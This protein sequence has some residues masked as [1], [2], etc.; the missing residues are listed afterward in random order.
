MEIFILLAL[1]FV[2]ALF[3]ISEIALVSARKSRLEHQAERGDQR[4]RTALELSNN[5][6]KFLSAAQ[7]G[8]T[9]IAILTG[10]YSGERFARYIQPSIEKISFLK[11]YAAT[12]STTIIVILVTFLSI[13]FGELIPKRIGL[14]RAERIAKLVAGPMN[15]FARFTHPFVWLLNK[16]SN[17]FFRIFNIRRSKDDAVTEEEIKTLI[18]EGTEAGTIDEAEQHII[19]RVFHLGDRNITS[20]MTHRSDI[21]WFNLDDN[22]DKIKE[23]IISEPH[24]AYP[25]CDGLI[26]NIK[27]VVSIKDLYVSPDSTLFKDIMQPALFI[28]ENNSPYQVLEKFKESQIHSAFIV[29]EYGSILG[30]LTLNDIL[31]A[32]VG[33]IPQ[34]AGEDYEIINREDGTYL[35]DGQITFYNFLSHFGKTEWMNEGEHD[36]DT[37]AGFIL[38]E[39]ERIPKTGDKLNWKDFSMEVIDMDGHRID[40]VLVTLSEELKE[41]IEERLDDRG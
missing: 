8:I 21:I 27:G 39:L 30:L 28:P 41:N 10:V 13:I 38:H 11:E 9:L 3:V 16:T 23:K 12:V 2:N 31:E 37:L 17:L 34:N 18:T 1:I 24:S 22:E 26:D 36:F 15:G 40:K 32:I 7:I 5:P 35:V 29:D 14:L 19:E 4:A 25:I 33:D 6:E 20:L